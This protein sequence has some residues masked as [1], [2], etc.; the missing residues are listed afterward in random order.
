MDGRTLL[1]LCAIGHQTGAEAVPV[2]GSVAEQIGEPLGKV[3]RAG[4][5]G[6]A[7]EM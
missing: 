4:N 6:G 3:L 5:Y 2:V 1:K 7:Q